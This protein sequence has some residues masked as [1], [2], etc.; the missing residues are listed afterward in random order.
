MI[1]LP[2]SVTGQCKLNSLLSFPVSQ[3]ERRSKSGRKESAH[4]NFQM[5]AAVYL[6]LS[7]PVG[8]YQGV[9]PFPKQGLETL[10]SMQFTNGK[11]TPA[12]VEEEVD[13]KTPSS[14]SKSGPVG[15]APRARS[16]DRAHLD[17]LGER[18]PGDGGARSSAS[19]GC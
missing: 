2:F 5:W 12:V 7:M 6:L 9:R 10:P 15:A 8:H 4:R 13:N 19:F 14:I 18:V 11:E 3:R 16:K 1:K 17:S